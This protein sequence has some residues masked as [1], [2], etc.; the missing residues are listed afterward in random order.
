M[1][2]RVRQNRSIHLRSGTLRSFGLNYFSP[3]LPKS[4]E[5]TLEYG[6]LIREHIEVFNFKGFQNGFECAQN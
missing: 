4:Q 1:T 6:E 5:F 3:I 2:A